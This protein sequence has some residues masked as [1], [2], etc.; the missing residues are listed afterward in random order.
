APESRGTAL[1]F[2]GTSLFA[3]GFGDI[4]PTSGLARLTALAAAATGLGIIALVIT[5]LFTLYASFQRREVAVVV[6]QAGAGAPP[7]GVTLLETY[8]V[9]GIVEDL[10]RVFADWQAWAAEV[11]DSHLAYPLT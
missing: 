7:S 11:L 6:L 5:F 3:I 9:G 2:G 8:A 1:H 10:P 4:V